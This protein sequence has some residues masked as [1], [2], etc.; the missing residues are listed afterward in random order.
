MSRERKPITSQPGLEIEEL[1]V[2]AR[3]GYGIKVR[4]YRPSKQTERLPLLVYMH[5]GGWVTGSLETDDRSCRALVASL[6]LIVLNVEYRLAPEHKF[7]I[8]FEDSFDVV[9]WLRAG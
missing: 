6:P 5:G 1:D 2:P 3:D 8:G 9:K 7:P 4:C